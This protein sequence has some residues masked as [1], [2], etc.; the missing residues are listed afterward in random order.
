MSLMEF[1]VVNHFMGPVATKLMKG[2]SDEDLSYQA[3]KVSRPPRYNYHPHSIWCPLFNSFVL[4]PYLV[5]S[6]T[7]FSDTQGRNID[8]RKGRICARSGPLGRASS[9]NLAAVRHILSRTRSGLVHRQVV[10]FVFPLFL[11]DPQYCVLGDVPPCPSRIF[12]NKKNRSGTTVTDDQRN[13]NYN[14]WSEYKAFQNP[15]SEK[16]TAQTVTEL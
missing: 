10:A 6:N 8:Q 7:F 2:Y 1:A 3:V 11:H 16:K 5:S 4:F 9:S 12:L 14:P 15:F 13:V